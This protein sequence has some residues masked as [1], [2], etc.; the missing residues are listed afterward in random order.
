MTTAELLSLVTFILAVLCVLIALV[1][2]AVLGRTRIKEVDE[3]VYGHKFEHD[4]I[5][6]QIARAPLYMLV[7]S[8][9]WYARR[10][11]QLAFYENFDSKFKRPFVITHYT[12][13]LGGLFMIITWLL[14]NF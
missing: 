13:L 10:T 7:F 6:F 5:F 3:F 12:F 14:D 8:S 11:G 1:L 4:S 9:R 2:L